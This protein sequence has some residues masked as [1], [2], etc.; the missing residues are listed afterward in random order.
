MFVGACDA[1]HTGPEAIDEILAAVAQELDDRGRAEI[2][3]IERGTDDPEP[4][5]HL[6]APDLENEQL[7]RLQSIASAIEAVAVRPVVLVVEDLHWAGRTTLLVLRHLIRL[8]E[9]DNLLVVAT[10]RDEDLAA[11]QAELIA[12]LAPTART[13]LA[14]VGTT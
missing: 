12:D 9:L 13:Q 10:V 14:V 3:G 5:A 1:S 8:S 6:A 2:A 11:G 4:L 7:R